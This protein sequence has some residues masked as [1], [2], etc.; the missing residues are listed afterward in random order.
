MMFVASWQGE[1]RTANFS[2]LFAVWRH[3]T[4]K[5]RATSGTK[6]LCV[7]NHALPTHKKT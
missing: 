3:E 7:D 2:P 6:A 1:K 4:D 5:G